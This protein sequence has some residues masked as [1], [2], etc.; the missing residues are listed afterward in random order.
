MFDPITYMQTLH[1]SLKTTKDTYKFCRVSGVNELEEVLESF[2]NNKYF[3]AVDDSQDG[4]TF[5]A[6]GGGY[7]ERRQYT[8]YV[9]GR[10]DYGKMDQRETVLSEA[11]GIFRSILSK[12]IKDKLSIPVLSAESIR[13]YEVPPAF[14]FGS[15]GLYFIFTVENPVNLVYNAA[16]WDN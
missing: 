16:E 6:P 1:G 9:F 12:L 5:R 2:K 4:V 14:A 10:A 8:V 11:K 15:A 3:F 7:F 13:F